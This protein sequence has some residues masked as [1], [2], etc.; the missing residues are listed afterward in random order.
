MFK[1]TIIYVVV[2]SPFKYYCS[3]KHVSQAYQKLL[4]HFL[5]PQTFQLFTHISPGVGTN[6]MN[7]SIIDR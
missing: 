2:N 5:F 1:L 3:V 6:F 7:A 4:D